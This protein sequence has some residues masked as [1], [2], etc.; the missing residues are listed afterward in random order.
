MG[1]FLSDTRDVGKL[2]LDG[3]SAAFVLVE[4]NKNFYMSQTISGLPDGNYEVGVQSFFRYGSR[5]VAFQAHRNGTE[6][7]NAKLFANNDET[8]V[9]SLYDNS[10]A[11]R[12]G[13]ASY[14]NYPDN[15]TQ[16]NQAFNAYG[17]Y[18]NKVETTVTDGTLVV[19]LY[20][21][22]WLD[23][24]WCCFDNFTLTYLGPLTSVKAV[25]DDNGQ[26]EDGVYNLKGQRLHD[27][28]TQRGIYISNGQKITIK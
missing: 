4:W 19:G 3:A 9:M 17:L 6:Q 21:T 1:S 28:A 12:Y 2:R 7:L 26:R 10:A 15:V 13:T 11:K 24:D 14:D 8:P 25:R 18:Y 22:D 16:A 20:K 5:D 23:S 27:N